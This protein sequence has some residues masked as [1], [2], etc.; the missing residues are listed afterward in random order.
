MKEHAKRNRHKRAF[1]RASKKGLRRFL[2]VCCRDC[3][4]S[5]NLRPWDELHKQMKE[6]HGVTAKRHQKFPY[7]QE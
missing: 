2:I 4:A 5:S 6:N 1:C 7:A 3:P